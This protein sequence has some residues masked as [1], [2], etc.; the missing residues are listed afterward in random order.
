MP[1]ILDQMLTNQWKIYHGLTGEVPCV[2]LRCL[3]APFVKFFNE[4]EWCCLLPSEVAIWRLTNTWPH[5]PAGCGF[6]LIGHLPHHMFE[7]LLWFDCWQRGLDGAVQGSTAHR[8]S[9]LFTSP[10]LPLTDSMICKSV[11]DSFLGDVRI[12]RA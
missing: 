3:F 5:W 4:F 8:D 9:F 11:C 6:C 7:V 2:L 10:V 12:A 1:G